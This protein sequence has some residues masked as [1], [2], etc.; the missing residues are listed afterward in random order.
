MKTPLKIAHTLLMTVIMVLALTAGTPSKSVI[1]AQIEL[2]QYGPVNLQFVRQPDDSGAAYYFV[3]LVEDC[4]AIY[5]VYSVEVYS[6]S[7]KTLLH[8]Y[9]YD[10]ALRI[11]ND[12]CAIELFAYRVDGEDFRRF[13]NYLDEC[14]VLVHHSLG[15]WYFTFTEKGEDRVKELILPAVEDTL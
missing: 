7:S 12:S 10:A 11:V 8:T 15:T 14:T 2:A 6:E 5:G 1:P 3:G 9:E 4:N 13:L